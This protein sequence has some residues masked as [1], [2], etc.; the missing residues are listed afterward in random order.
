MINGESLLVNSLL[1]RRTLP[2]DIDTK[3]CP[4]YGVK[5]AMIKPPDSA[6]PVSAG[7][8]DSDGY[9]V[10]TPGTGAFILRAILCKGQTDPGLEYSR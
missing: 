1:A 10:L 9:A 3:I 7:T 2:K 8:T 5:F 4:E 6:K